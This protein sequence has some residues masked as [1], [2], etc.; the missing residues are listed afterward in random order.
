MIKKILKILKI[1]FICLFTSFAF[2]PKLAKAENAFFKNYPKEQK[3]GFTLQNR[4]QKAQ[5]GD[6]ILTLQNNIYTLLV[7][8]QVQNDILILEEAAFPLEI[9]KNKPVADYKSFLQNQLK[10]HS[11]EAIVWN[12]YKIDLKNQKLLKA[13]SLKHKS[14]LKLSD[15]EHFLVKMLN[16]PLT[17][18]PD[19]KR[20]KI[21][22]PVQNGE[23]DRRKNWQ[24]IKFFEGQKIKN[25]VFWVLETFW[26]K[27]GSE[28]ANKTLEFYF[29]AENQNFCFPYFVQ[30]HTPE[31]T[32]FLKA[33][34]SGKNFQ[35]SKQINF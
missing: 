20:K 14:I 31:I 7:I 18:L 35:G 32:V 33:V 8:N 4:L 27:D 16:L 15:K 9:L 26:P 29:D 23:I 19:Y 11:P 34:D 30:I 24:P 25:P 3:K 1:S 21:G 10:K 12:L 28:L 13:Y 6:Y 17:I 5:M 22:S 2:I